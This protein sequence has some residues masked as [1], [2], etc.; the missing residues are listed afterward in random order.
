[1]PDAFAPGPSHPSAAPLFAG[2]A[3]RGSTMRRRTL[4][5]TSGDRH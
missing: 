3:L 1:M 2:A 5:D 4:K